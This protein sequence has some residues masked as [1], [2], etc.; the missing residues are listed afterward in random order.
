M[1]NRLSKY[2]KGVFKNEETS[3]VFASVYYDS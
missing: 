2:Q 3:S 1:I